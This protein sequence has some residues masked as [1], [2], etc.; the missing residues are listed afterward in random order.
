[1][2]SDHLSP[3]QQGLILSLFPAGT[4]IIR[5]SYFQRDYLPCPMRVQVV[6]PNG[7]PRQVVLRLSRHPFGVEREALLLPILAQLG[8]SVPKVLAGPILD[9]D[10]GSGESI[11]ILSLLAGDNLQTWSCASATGLETASQL[12]IEAVAHLHR[13]TEPLTQNQF[14]KQLPHCDMMTELRGITNNKNL[15][16]REPRFTSA[17][18]RL[19]PVIDSIKTPLIF[20]NG[21]YQPGNFLS[22]GKILTGFVDFERACF[23]DPHI[24][25]AKYRI[26]DLHPLNKAGFI[27]R[28]LQAC[29]LTE[30]DFAPRM[31]VRC[32][33]TLQREVAVNEKN[34]GYGRHIL[35]LLS[36]ALDLI[37]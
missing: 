2:E 3:F 7:D 14:A 16:N 9:P 28:Y 22:D 5:A 13:L 31:A 6:L 20:S 29:G 10:S 33:H 32:L 12:L 18:Q 23:E 1:M 15:W 34:G 27:E 37:N 25:F 24:G 21:D 17:I 11:T 35:T 4:Q 8:L 36:R 30:R 26:Y 19:R